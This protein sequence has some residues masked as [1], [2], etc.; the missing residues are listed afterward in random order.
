MKATWRGWVGALTVGVVAIASAAHGEGLPMSR[1]V[2]GVAGVGADGTAMCVVTLTR[3]DR[4]D[5][6][7]GCVLATQGE[8]GALYVEP[9]AGKC[10]ADQ[11][12]AVIVVSSEDDDWVEAM[13]WVGAKPTGACALVLTHAPEPEAPG[14]YESIGI[15]GARVYLLDEDDLIATIGETRDDPGF[16]EAVGLD[17]ARVYILDED[18]RI[19]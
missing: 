19:E 15:D 3:G 1:G 5:A 6:L 11:T 18:D 17:G 16:F 14:L 7:R 12:P 4:F 13:R 9:S 10:R 2:A 8:A